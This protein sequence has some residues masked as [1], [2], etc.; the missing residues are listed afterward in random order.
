MVTAKPGTP[1]SSHSEVLPDLGEKAKRF[2]KA[3]VSCIAF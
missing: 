3:K 1:L 2:E